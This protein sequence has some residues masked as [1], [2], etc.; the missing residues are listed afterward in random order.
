MSSNGASK[1]RTLVLPLEVNVPTTMFSVQG[2]LYARLCITVYIC[3]YA[4]HIDIL[5]SWNCETENGLAHQ[6]SVLQSDLEKSIKDNAMLF[7]KIGTVI[8]FLPSKVDPLFLHIV[9][10]KFTSALYFVVINCSKRG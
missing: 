2:Q 8:S 4:S 5:V 1:A 3:I 7:S 9:V 6:A 10:A